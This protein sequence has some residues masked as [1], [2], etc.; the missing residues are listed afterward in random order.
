MYSNKKVYL[1]FGDTVAYICNKC[2]LIRFHT[3]G[4]HFMA[5]FL[6]AGLFIDE[7]EMSMSLPRS[8]SDLTVVFLI[9][10]MPFH[11]VYIYL[12]V[13]FS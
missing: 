5:H 2:L 1:A 9:I 13:M 12:R 7:S 4:Y 11:L 8:F 10:L 3:Y 6:S